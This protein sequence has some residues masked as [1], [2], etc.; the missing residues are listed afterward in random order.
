MP[1]L[2]YLNLG[3][4]ATFLIMTSFGHFLGTRNEKEKFLNIPTLVKEVNQNREKVK[5]YF[6]DEFLTYEELDKL[7]SI[8]DP[9]P[10]SKA[11]TSHVIGRTERGG[12]IYSEFYNLMKEGTFLKSKD[13]EITVHGENGREYPMKISGQNTS[14]TNLSKNLDKLLVNYKSNLKSKEHSNHMRPRKFYQRFGDI[15]TLFH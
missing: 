2:K 9:L 12:E 3:F 4:L 5:T 13:Y 8:F 15:R 7:R 14:G 11:L 1:S 6:K 10:V